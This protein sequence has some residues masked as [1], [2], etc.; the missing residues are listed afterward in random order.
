MRS[1]RA[2]TAAPAHIVQGSRVTIRVQP[3]S[4]HSPRRMAA[5]RSATISACAV[6]SPV[7]SR[8]LR[9]GPM[10]WPDGA[11][12]TGPTGTSPAA[13]RA[14]RRAR[15]IAS[16]MSGSRM[17]GLPEPVVVLG[18]PGS[19]GD[20]RQ[21]VTGGGPL[22]QFGQACRLDA[23]VGE[24]SWITDGVVGG[25]LV[26]LADLFVEHSGEVA[27]LGRPGV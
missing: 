12:V 10:S 9:P 11:G 20:D 27:G 3:V 13:L 14:S 19:F 15:R 6:G 26:D 17:T 18:E 22:A 4:R 24:E 16:R 8:S 25:Y 7:R 1:R 5:R 23:E 21:C 2:S